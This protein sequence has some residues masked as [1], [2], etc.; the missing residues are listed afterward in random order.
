MATG[1]YSP[2]TPTSVEALTIT[3]TLTRISAPPI[4]RTFTTVT[5]LT[6][7]KA[8]PTGEE[9]SRARSHSHH[10]S[11]SQ[12]GAIVGSILGFIVLLALLCYCC[13]P[14]REDI[15]S[16]SESSLEPARSRGPPVPIAGGVYH[17]P[18][19]EKPKNTT[20]I[21]HPSVVERTPEG[22]IQQIRP[23]RR[24]RKPPMNAPRGEPK[25]PILPVSSISWFAG[26]RPHSHHPRHVSDLED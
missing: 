2:S 15:Y 9:G 23:S 19:V 22:Y 20:R 25:N 18:A 13:R 3:Q 1:R 8:T 12:K 6:L 14:S 17:Q 21:R 10:L 16:D 5:T 26:R 4:T 24:R 7:S 11:P